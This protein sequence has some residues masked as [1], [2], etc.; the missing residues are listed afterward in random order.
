MEDKITYLQMKR[1][2]LYFVFTTKFNISPSIS[3]EFLDRVIHVLKDYCGIVNE[4]SIRK[5]FTLVYEI[6][7]ELVVCRSVLNSAVL[8]IPA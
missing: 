7:D 5:N 3:M 4:E 6:M 8:L 1:F 2:G